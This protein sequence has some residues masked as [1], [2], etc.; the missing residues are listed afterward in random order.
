MKFLS[1]V[2]SFFEQP[3]NVITLK[4][5]HLK[6]LAFVFFFSFGFYGYFTDRSFGLTLNLFIS[7]GLLCIFV[8]TLYVG[9]KR[10]L[11][12]YTFILTKSHVRIA[13][14]F[15]GILVTTLWQQVVLPISSD[16]FYHTQQALLYGIKITEKITPFVHFFSSVPFSWLVWMANSVIIIFAIILVRFLRHKALLAQLIIYSFL[17]LFFRFAVFFLGGNT[18]PFPPFRLFPLLIS[19]SFF[20]I[21]EI[22]FRFTSLAP[23]IVL[24]TGLFFFIRKRLSFIPSFF[25]VISIISTPLLAH[26]G[27][28]VES[29]V[30]T[31]FTWTVLLFFF[32]K[33]DSTPSLYAAMFSLITVASYM[34]VSAF[35]AVIPLLLHFFIAQKRTLDEVRVFIS[36]ISIQGLV[37]VPLVAVSSILKGAA[38]YQ[39]EVYS[40]YGVHEH[41]AL[42]SRVFAAYQGGYIEAALYNSLHLLVL[43]PLLLIFL[44]KKKELTSYALLLVTGFLLFFSIA[45]E[46]WG[47]GRYQAEYFLPFVVVGLVLFYVRIKQTGII[48]S[49][50]FG[51]FL[52]NT[53]LF[54]HMNILNANYV[55]K[56][57]YFSDAKKRGDYF[58]M[59]ET[60]YEY[61]EPLISLREKGYARE[62]LYIPGNGYSYIA[63]ILSGYSP[64]D[65]SKEKE[66]RETFG[67]TLGTTSP[68][69]IGASKDV[70]YIVINRAKKDASFTNEV[71]LR[72]LLKSSHWRLIETY[73]DGFYGNITEVYSR[74]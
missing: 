56:S 40:I 32:L 64:E 9:E 35:V 3:G 19:S 7:L 13:G 31:F 71:F 42:F 23:V 54:N 22:V 59:S 53:Y 70:K 69:L 27:L 73:T 12:H 49:V 24:A 67:V 51:I 18:S 55:G 15:T 50:A 48:I 4:V 16:N 52:Y 5:S 6:V 61:Q 60:P 17:F 38:A 66:F 62:I 10:I 20:G 30:W 8:G 2:Q 74:L 26:V 41:A 34:R 43:V 33:S 37:L 45:P 57:S 63:K 58:V 1:V 11:D 36:L 29:S 44:L 46:L 68:E 65:L 25:V 47:N 14:L 21:N 28:L 72:A 39:G